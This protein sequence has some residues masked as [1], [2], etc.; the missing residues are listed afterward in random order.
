MRKPWPPVRTVTL[1]SVA[2]GL[3]PG[4][5]AALTISEVLYDAAGADDGRVFV[6]LFGVPGKGLDGFTL[7]GVNGADGAVG[8]V[9]ELVGLIPDDGFFVVAD[10]AAGVSEITGAELWIDFDLQNGPDSLVLRGPDG[11]V[12]DALGYGRFGPG[13][14]FAGEGSPAPDAPA[15]QSLARRSPAI[16]TDDN[17]ADFVILAL[18][19]PGSGAQ[20]VPEPAV[21]GL[22]LAA[23]GALRAV[24]RGLRT[25]RGPGVCWTVLRSSRVRRSGALP[26]ADAA[27]SPEVATELLRAHPPGPTRPGAPACG[28]PHFGPECQSFGPDAR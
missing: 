7:E 5:A 15:G 10:V 18:P 22:L 2:L 26:P 14:T 8:P 27:P 3:L 19:S 21:G 4:S 6:E 24:G 28:A 13:T 25:P 20:P 9:L 1:L 16:D 23:L 11:R 12:V 17:G